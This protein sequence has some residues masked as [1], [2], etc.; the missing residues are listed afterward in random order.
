ML[1]STHLI[2]EVSDLLEHVVLI[3]RGRILLAGSAD[4]L[5]GRAITVTGPTAAVDRFAAPHDE[6]HREQLGGVSRVMVAGALTK[7][8][9]AMA[10]ALGL[11]VEAV[12]PYD[13]SWSG[14]P[15][16]GRRTQDEPDLGGPADLRGQLAG[17]GGL[18]LGHP[19]LGVRHQP[20]HLRRRRRV[21]L[22]R[23]HHRWPAV[24]LHRGAVFFLQLFTQ[25]LPFLLGP[26]V[27]RKRFF[28]SVALAAVLQALTYG[29]V[30]TALE[31][32][33]SATG[34][35]GLDLRFF[36]VPFLTVG[37]PLL[38]TLCTPDRSCS[39][40]SPAR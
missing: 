25:S 14:R 19:G 39:W 24:D 8:D 1:L 9:H 40:P 4:D 20:G 12:C 34:G 29:V 17:R 7:A 22:G 21:G 26:G 32:L 11:D 33:E 27:T 2:D 18:A 30:L 28:T 15:R 3:D 10:G 36:G 5:R 23:R 37:N 16:G 35:W 31:R 6:L 38:Q 13:S